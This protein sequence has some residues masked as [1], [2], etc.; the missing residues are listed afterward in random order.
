MIRKKNMNSDPSREIKNPE[1]QLAVDSMV[2]EYEIKLRRELDMRK[3]KSYTEIERRTETFYDMLIENELD[4]IRRDV[5]QIREEEKSIVGITFWISLSI[6]VLVIIFALFSGEKLVAVADNISFF[7]AHNLSWFY[8]LLASGFLI[9]LFYLAFGRFG[10][11]VLGPPNERPEFSDFSWYSMLFSAGMGV[12]ILFWGTAE[13]MSHFL[14]PPTDMPVTV[15]SAKSAMAYTAFHWGFHAWGVY[16]ICALGTAYYGFRK[17]KKYLISSSILDFTKKK[18][19]RKMIKAIV[20]LIA[21]LAV[22]FGV[23]AS[24]GLGVLQI[25]GGVDYVFGW[26]T[27]N[28]AGYALITLLITV[29]FVISSSTGLEKG[30]RILSNL[31][32]LTAI[33]LLIFVFIA[34]NSLFDLKVFV[35]SIGQYLQR[36]PEFSFKVDPYEPEYE[37]WMGNWT[38]SYFTWWMAWSP[39]VGIFIARISKGRTIKE[40][41]IGCLFIPVLFS[42]LWF[43][44]FGGSAIAMEL[45]GDSTI[46]ER[47]VSNVN[48]GTFVFLEQLPFDKVTSVVALLLLF[49]FLVTSADSATFV[50]SMMTSEGDLDPKLR[51]KVIWGVVLATLSLLLLAGG[52]LKA[53]QAATLIFAFPFA[54]VLVLIARTLYF[55]LSIQ[56]KKRRE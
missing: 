13:P 14:H 18:S 31:N 11:V 51:L 34:G 43:S 1:V 9:F 45:F 56:V 36:L 33:A 27:Q 40:L 37:R 5:Q 54:I 41:I 17:R 19:S 53:L 44:V 21:I 4:D 48:L 28:F 35:D 46:G 15:E 42:I 16:T 22:V 7:I 49:T 38:L 20:D 2:E 29:I 24:L 50:I 26:D 32:M 8:V 52:G 10:R 30:I 6:A 23:S 55:R 39:F 12:G 3:S 25:S 47:I